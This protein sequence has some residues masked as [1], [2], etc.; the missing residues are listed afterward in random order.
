MTGEYGVCLFDVSTRK[1]KDISDTDLV[2]SSSCI[3]LVYLLDIIGMTYATND[4][5]IN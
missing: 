5:L 4:F 1:W 2:C 3:V